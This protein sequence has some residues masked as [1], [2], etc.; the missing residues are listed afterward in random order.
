MMQLQSSVGA[1]PAGWFQVGWSHELDRGDVRPLRFCGEDL[2]LC[3]YDSGEIGLFDAYCPHMGAHIGYGGTTDGETLV[4]PYHGW[5]FDRGGCNTHVPYSDRVNRSACLRLRH[6]SE[7]GGAVIVAWYSPDGGAPSFDAPDVSALP[8]LADP[9]FF[10]VGP[11]TTRR[12]DS[13][14]MR[15]GF[16]SENT[17]DMSHFR[18]VH[19]TPYEANII[20]LEPLDHRLRVRFSMPM[21]LYGSD[22]SGEI[23]DAL[24]DVTN[25]GLGLILIRFADGSMQLQAQ[26]PI[27]DTLCDVMLTMIMPRGASNTDTLSREHMAR[28]KMAW[29]QVEN[30]IVI[31]T[32]RRPGMQARLVAEEVAPFKTFAAWSNQFYASTPRRNGGR[33]ARPEPGTT[34]PRTEVGS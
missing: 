6:V 1:L 2:V 20:E 21:K 19:E 8:G 3:R 24:T 17:V 25:W 31:W 28:L 4:C 26:T 12:Y 34:T 10:P 33:S 29:R 30:D 7:V 14:P 5:R 22:G 9:G 27:D 18:F 23:I 16:V 11:D 13:L 15:V 32:H